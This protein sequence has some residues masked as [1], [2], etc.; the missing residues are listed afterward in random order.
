MGVSVAKSPADLD[1][2]SGALFWKAKFFE[3]LRIVDA[4]GQA[5]EVVSAVVRKPETVIGQWLARFF[6]TRVSV[7]AEIR[8]IG[9]ISLVEVV[10]AVE[11]SIDEEPELFEELTGREAAST[12][13]A[14]AKC[15]NVGDIARLLASGKV[16]G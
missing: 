16:D 4:T 13:Q 12:K 9:Q 8:P 5:H 3:G 10:S 11:T 15:A 7:K 14:L 2:V 1:K 6:D